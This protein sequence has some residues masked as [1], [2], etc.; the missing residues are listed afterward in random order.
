[1]SA[2]VE[3]GFYEEANRPLDEDII[4]AEEHGY[5]VFW[6]DC[7]KAPDGNC[8]GFKAALRK[9]RTDLGG[10]KLIVLPRDNMPE[11]LTLTSWGKL[12]R[13][14]AFDTAAMT[15]F[16]RRNLGQAPEPNGP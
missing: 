13:L 4:H 11:M 14:D 16:Y 6:Y 12:Q 1:M 15:A 8:D 10:I 7:T 2:P 3:A 5:V 9:L